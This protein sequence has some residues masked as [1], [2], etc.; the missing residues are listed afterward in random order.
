MKIIKHKISAKRHI[1]KKCIT[2]T[3]DEDSLIGYIRGYEISFG[4]FIV[5][6]VLKI[7]LEEHKIDYKE[8]WDKE[9]IVD[10]AYF[11]IKMF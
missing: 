2:V 5:K 11:D 10:M 8:C 4:S 9:I 1:N 3:L 6:D 7:Y